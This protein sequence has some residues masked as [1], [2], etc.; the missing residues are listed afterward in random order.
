VRHP[1]DLS[2]GYHTPGRG[3]EPHEFDPTVASRA[4]P[5]KVRR[6]RSPG[7]T[8]QYVEG[9]TVARSGIRHGGAEL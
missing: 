7:C 2:E 9:A 8:Y 6:R 3:A 5:G 1:L 4:A